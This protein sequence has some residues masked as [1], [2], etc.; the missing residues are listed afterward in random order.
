LNGQ[1]HLP[2]KKRARKGIQTQTIARLIRLANR[3]VARCLQTSFGR[4]HL[5]G[6][7]WHYL[8]T[9]VEEDG[10]TQRELSQRIDT[11]EVGTL[12]QTEKMEVAGLVRRVRDTHDRRVVRIFVTKLGR[13]THEKLMPHAAEIIC[14]ITAGMSPKEIDILRQLLNRATANIQDYHRA[15][16]A[17]MDEENPRKSS[18][19]RRSARR[20]AVKA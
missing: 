4:F 9:L 12:L 7:A 2:D 20:A 16:I 13:K 5:A 11:S 19:R 18:A 14:A 3:E 17:A 15:I 10:I 8:N 6:G 1:Q